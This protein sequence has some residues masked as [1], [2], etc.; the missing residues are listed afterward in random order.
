MRHCGW[1]IKQNSGIKARA[2]HAEE[3]DVLR[4]RE[5]K[6][7]CKVRKWKKEREYSPKSHLGACCVCGSFPC[8]NVDVHKSFNMCFCV[9]VCVCVCVRKRVC[10]G[11]W[12]VEGFWRGRAEHSCWVVMS[13]ELALR[14]Q[15]DSPVYVPLQR[16]NHTV[17]LSVCVCASASVCVCVCVSL[18]DCV[19]GSW[20][21]WGKPR[22][23]RE[24]LLSP[25]AQGEGTT[26]WC[27]PLKHTHRKR[28]FLMFFRAQ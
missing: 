8:E 19:I 18:S 15:T 5:M 10:A 11:C 7:N 28:K 21:R 2:S 9:C 13:W 3:E 12:P 14:S 20:G 4:K 24:G 23:T 25:A 16:R 17:C 22:G 1:K 6:N 26:Y 27:L